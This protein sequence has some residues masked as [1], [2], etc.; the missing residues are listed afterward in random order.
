[1]KKGLLIILSGPSGVGKGTVRKKIIQ[2]GSIEFVYSISMT[3][4][5]PRKKEKNGVDYYFVSDEV[6]EEHVKNDDF[7]EHAEFVGHKYGTPKSVIEQLRNEGKNVFLEIEVNGATQVLEKLKDDPGVLSIFLL[8]PS[9]RVLE[10]R[11]RNRKSEPEE[12]IQQRLTKGMS[13]MGESKN[14]QYTVVN[15][16][17]KDAAQEIIDIVQKRLDESE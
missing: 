12:I 3:T 9:K 11:I 10:Q 1:M 2:L 15:Y 6:F 5:E 7:L 14:Y 13:E 17:V 8:P 16:R 4:R